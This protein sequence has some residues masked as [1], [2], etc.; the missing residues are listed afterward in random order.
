VLPKAVKQATGGWRV[1]S[2]DLGRNYEE[3]LSIHPT[4]IRDFGPGAG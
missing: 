1:T 3:D 2:N 4:G